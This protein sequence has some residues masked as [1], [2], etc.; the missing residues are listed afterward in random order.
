MYWLPLTTNELSHH[1]HFQADSF[2][3]GWSRFWP[4]PRQHLRSFCSNFSL[5]PSLCLPFST[6]FNPFLMDSG[7]SWLLCIFHGRQWA[8]TTQGSISKSER[9]TLLDA[10]HLASNVVGV[11][12]ADG[13]V[14]YETLDSLERTSLKGCLLCLLFWEQI[15]PSVVTSIRATCG[16]WQ[17]GK[18]KRGMAGKPANSFLR[19]YQYGD[20]QSHYW[21]LQ[22]R[23]NGE[24]FGAYIPVAVVK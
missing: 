18:E 24:D 10:I 20:Y 16:E 14:L 11:P 8:R 5:H 17:K 3:E 7:C 22:L 6:Y 21:Q 1:L 19:Y 15:S 13:P 4:Q 23:Y 9:R 12:I 2:T